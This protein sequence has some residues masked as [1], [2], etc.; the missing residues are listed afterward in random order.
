MR[1]KYLRHSERQ[2]FTMGSNSARTLGQIP[3]PVGN[4][5]LVEYGNASAFRWRIPPEPM[6]TQR[7]CPAMVSDPTFHSLRRHG[8]DRQCW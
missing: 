2:Y 8:V 4:D 5:Q 1:T 6:S 7:P 3:T